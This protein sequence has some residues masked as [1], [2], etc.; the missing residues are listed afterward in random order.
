M[1]HIRPEIYREVGKRAEEGRFLK[2]LRQK[3]KAVINSLEGRYEQRS[4]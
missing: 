1:K 2:E 4:G 3:V